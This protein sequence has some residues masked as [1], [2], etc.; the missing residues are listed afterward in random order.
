MCSISL[1]RAQV[2][3]LIDKTEKQRLEGIVVQTR[4]PEITLI[5]NLR[6]EIDIS[7]LQS[8]DTLFFTTGIHETVVLSKPE[9]SKLKRIELVPLRH[10][11]E[12]IVISASRWE[13]PAERTA[14]RITKITPRSIM[15]Q[16]PQTSADLLESSGEVFVQKSQLAGG[17]PILRGFA[18]NRV[19]LV[20]D[21]VRMNNAIFRG[22]NLQ[23]VISVDANAL[24]GAEVLFGPGAV[25]YGSDAIGGVMDFHTLNTR[26]ADTGRY[27]RT[28]AGGHLMLRHSTANRER[29]LHADAYVATGRMSFLTSFTRSLYDDLRAGSQGDPF[30]LRPN[31]VI[32]RG[33]RDTM[34]KNSDPSLQVGSAFSQDNFMQKIAFRLDPHHEIQYTLIYARSSDAPRYDRLY[35]DANNDSILDFGDWHYGPQTWLFNRLAFE[36][37]RETGFSDHYKI[38]AAWQQFGES[39][40][41]RRYKNT[42]LRNQIE[43]VNAFS[44]NLDLDRRISGRTEVFYGTEFIYNLINSEAYRND[45]VT[46]AERLVQTRYPDNSTWLTAGAYANLRHNLT[47]KLILSGALRFTHYGLAATFDTTFMAY[48]FM[49]VRNSNNA[50]NGSAGLTWL[51]D[52][53]TRLYINLSTGFRAPNIDDAGKVFE[54]EAGSLV[55]PNNN[56]RHEY[57]YSGEAGMV[58][59]AGKT[60]RAEASVYYT[61]LNNAMARRST[62]YHGNDSILFEG[63]LSRVQSIQNIARAN[64]YGV[65]G[66]IQLTIWNFMF[67]GKV[68]WQRGYENSGPG[69]PIYPKTHVPPFFSRADIVYK[70]TDLTLDL[71]VNYHGALPYERLSLNDREDH[72]PFAKT[73]DGLPHVPSWYTLNFKA[74]WQINR[75]F[76]LSGGVENITDQLYRPFSSGISAPGRNFIIALR[77]NLER[78]PK[79]QDPSPSAP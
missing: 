30:Y 47:S 75:Y 46:G 8:D 20:V 21:G 1:L 63:Q 16:N 29:T 62:T 78:S 74:N 39:R 31:Y 42:S 6:G 28:L 43:K 34:V 4:N 71:Y 59:T 27:S 25:R 2:I 50:L 73:P 69:E 11:L 38:I 64:V 51:P 14:H 65:Q 17:S 72:I 49:S 66:S 79:N 5:S 23:N 24:Q 32:P 56:L 19:L 54:S 57:A 13:E 33:A 48:P 53:K 9:A 68:S 36:S 70:Q 7:Q 37:K 10:H 61:L 52:K 22:G 12:E 76:L 45:I 26:F 18:T 77:V 15:L 40:H 60:L 58:K 55:I 44:L 41:D 67:S 3:T 35:Q